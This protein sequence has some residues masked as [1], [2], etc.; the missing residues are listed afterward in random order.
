MEFFSMEKM[1]KNFEC[2]LCLLLTFYNI[3]FKFKI[4]HLLHFVPLTELPSGKF[5]MKFGDALTHDKSEV[6]KFLILLISHTFFTS[7]S[8]SYFLL[9]SLRNQHFVS[10][11]W[12][13]TRAAVEEE[14]RSSKISKETCLRRKEEKLYNEINFMGMRMSSHFYELCTWQWQWAFHLGVALEVV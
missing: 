2:I 6:E 13:E 7:S 11:K 4:F 1:L 14:K 3:L 10:G 8:I 9:R 5:F 12:W